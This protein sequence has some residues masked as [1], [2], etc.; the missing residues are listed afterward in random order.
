MR[1]VLFNE[2]STGDTT[3]MRHFIR[4]LTVKCSE[5]SVFPM[6]AISLKAL[7]KKITVV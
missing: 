5:Q 7:R 3:W 1:V 2:M 6:E 4:D